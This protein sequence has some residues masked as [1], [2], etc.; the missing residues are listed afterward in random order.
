MSPVL[1]GL[2]A[3]LCWGV[4][5]WW[6]RS[7]SQALGSFRAQLWSQFS[8]LAILSVAVVVSG[9]LT[10]AIASGDGRAWGFCLLYAALI[11]AA[12]LCFFEAFGKGTLAVVAPIVG[13][14]GAVTVAWSLLFGARP[15]LFTFAGLAAVVAGAVLAS[16]PGPGGSA[17]GEKRRAPK[18]VYSAAAAAFLFGTAFFVLGREVAPVLGSLVPAF[19]SRLVGPLLLL[20]IAAVAGVSSAPPPRGLRWLAALS[21]A[22]ASAA[23]VATG[24]GSAGTGA[25][26]V[27]VLGSLSVVVTVLIGLLF[28]RE[29]LA[30][31]QW[32]GVA[33]ALIGIPL[34]A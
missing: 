17:A 33:L 8:G 3:A 14:Y 20:L 24:L 25:P 32:C 31:H 23:T 34:L 16:V 10:A 21:G 13:G 11:G 29:K 1:L 2:T 12:A 28:L 19:M 18:G 15:T 9:S 26:V 22:V 30:V 4:S 27:A 7:L 6:A 5:D